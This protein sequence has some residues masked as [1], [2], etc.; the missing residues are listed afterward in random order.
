MT[1]T[2]LSKV[3]ALFLALVMACSSFSAVAFATDAE[4]TLTD[5][6]T[7]QEWNEILNTVSYEEYLEEYSD[8]DLP[9]SS[10]TIDATEFV[11]ELTT[12]KYAK[13]VFDV[14]MDAEDSLYTSASGKVTWN[15]TVPEAGLY[16]VELECYPG[17]AELEDGNKEK[18]TAVERILYVNGKVPYSEARSISI[19]K[20][21]APQYTALEDGTVRFLKDVSGNDIRPDNASAIV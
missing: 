1:R 6:R 13:V 17:D 5:G 18:S 4:E 12:D 19:S 3:L 7:M 20:T 8:V 2:K 9:G 15:V 10:V 16:T 21:W 11:P 14:A